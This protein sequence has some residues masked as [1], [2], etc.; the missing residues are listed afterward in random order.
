M[1]EGPDGR[2]I[3]IVKKV[4]G[5]GGHHGGSW[6]V[7][8]ADFVTSMMCLFL[9][10]WL[11]N[12]SSVVT[13]EKIASYFK[14]PGV[15]E[16]GSGSP[17]QV[18]G[19]GFMPVSE[20]APTE[21]KRSGDIDYDIT[22]RKRDG[23]EDPNK[24]AG[25]SKSEMDQMRAV[26]RELEERLKIGG[27]GAKDGIKKKEEAKETQ[28]KE[29][30]LG[31]ESLE[32]G[33]LGKEKEM[34]ASIMQEKLGGLKIEISMDEYGLNL[35]IMDT[36][37]GSMFALGSSHINAEAEKRM[38]QI[39]Q[40]LA[41]IPNPIDIEGHTDGL[42][43]R[44]PS[45]QSF[46]NWD[47]SSERA[48]AARRIL[49][50]SG[51]DEKRLVRVAGF[52]DTRLKMPSKPEDPS[53]RRITVKLRYSGEAEK[54]IRDN[55]NLDYSL[56]TRPNREE[57]NS[58]TGHW[59]K[60]ENKVKDQTATKSVTEKNRT[61]SSLRVELSVGEEEPSHTRYEAKPP[62]STNRLEEKYLIFG[63]KRNFFDK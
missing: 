35:E 45:A 21:D 41:K 14:R 63:T 23:G 30:S 27:T 5:H 51:I 43:F 53:N 11:V 40:V 42:A 3:I 62:R 33:G 1:P 10:L 16:S 60:Y 24:K 19:I 54:A 2:A 28:Q 46:D 25:R 38:T 49:V 22:K 36:P 15:F 44:G 26:A 31:I 17:L 7:A 61:D 59:R 4:V 55:L 48:N 12:T 9:V 13:R 32:K 34:L 6:K 18:G 20:M 37:Q 50:S 39:G 58:Y 52:A 47:L 56:G 29:Q 57:E 8:Y